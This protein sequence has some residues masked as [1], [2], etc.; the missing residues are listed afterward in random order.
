MS[1]LLICLCITRWILLLEEKL[2]WGERTSLH[3]WN[4]VTVCPDPGREGG[5]RVFYL[6]NSH[7]QCFSPWTWRWKLN[8]PKHWRRRKVSAPF[9]FEKG[10]KVSDHENELLDTNRSVKT[11]SENYSLPFQTY[12]WPKRWYVHCVWS[13]VA[14]KQATP[15]LG[16]AFPISVKFFSF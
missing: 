3:T 6:L 1:Q 15:K 7:L 11:S 16:L 4:K 13:C 8:N 9:F 10:F 12:R 2:Y 5:N 14:L